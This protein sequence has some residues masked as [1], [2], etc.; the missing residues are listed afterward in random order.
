MAERI[1]ERL[2]DP[3]DPVRLGYRMAFFLVLS[4]AFGALLLW[5]VLP[6]TRPV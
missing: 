5:I 1:L 3:E 4:C 2:G 6:P